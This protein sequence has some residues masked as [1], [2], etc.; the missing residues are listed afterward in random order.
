MTATTA[1][2]ILL[3]FRKET[4]D[5]FFD[6][7]K[8]SDWLAHHVLVNFPHEEKVRHDTIIQWKLKSIQD[9]AVLDGLQGTYINDCERDA[10]LEWSVRRR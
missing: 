6:A 3:G 5:N 10:Y 2:V 7:K 9:H 4:L 8:R 1:Q